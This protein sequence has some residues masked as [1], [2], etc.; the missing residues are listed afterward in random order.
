MS[1]SHI[2]F[3]QARLEKLRLYKHIS[4]KTLLNK[5]NVNIISIH[6]NRKETP[7]Y[8]S[9]KGSYTI[10]ASVVL[11]VILCVVVFILFYLKS[12]YIQVGVQRAIDETSRQAAV[13]CP[14][15]K[16]MSLRELIILCDARL[17]KDEIPLQYIRG[18]I[19]G[20]SYANSSVDG[21]YINLTVDYSIVFPIKMFGNR[22]LHIQ[23]HSV[24]RK[25]I[26]WDAA[27]KSYAEG[28]VYVTEH[29]RVYHTKINCPHLKPKISAVGRSGIKDKRNRNGEKYKACHLCAKKGKKNVVFV[30]EYGNVYHNTLTCAGIKR[31]IYKRRIEEVG[32]LPMCEKCRGIQ[33]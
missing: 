12:F 21:N 14:Y 30:T 11:P 24:N 3:F 28:Y 29:G 8:T 13:L 9:R 16:D 6:K 10:E 1:L 5:H 31:T 19:L 4:K 33:K 17:E 22:Q 2:G 20:L 23:Q 7:L 18:N 27:E 32:A 26:G 15:K 25:W